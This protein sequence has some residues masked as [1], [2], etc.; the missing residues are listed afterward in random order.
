[1]TVW[2]AGQPSLAQTLS[3]APY[4]ALNSRIQVRIRMRA[5]NEHE[6]FA[7]LIKHALKAQG[8]ELRAAI[9]L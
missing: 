6:R 3:R 4:A 8:G 2:L 7:A 9:T 1:M 5:I